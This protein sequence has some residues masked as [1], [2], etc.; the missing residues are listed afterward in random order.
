MKRVLLLLRAK[1]KKT[2]ND[3]HNKRAEACSASPSKIRRA[4]LRRARDGQPGPPRQAGDGRARQSHNRSN[5]HLGPGEVGNLK[6]AE[7][8]FEMRMEGDTKEKM[9]HVLPS[10]LIKDPVLC[11]RSCLALGLALAQNTNSPDT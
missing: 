7:W 4:R 1:M 9:G 3:L 8:F 5:K 11:L 2:G 6:D 10:P